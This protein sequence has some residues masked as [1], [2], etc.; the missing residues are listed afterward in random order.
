[1]Q[2]YVLI[3]CGLSQI[4]FKKFWSSASIF[5]KKLSQP[6]TDSRPPGDQGIRNI[7]EFREGSLP[8]RTFQGQAHRPGS[9]RGQ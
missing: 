4:F 8:W 7:R 6:G 2:N 5:S 1:V 9:R 3:F